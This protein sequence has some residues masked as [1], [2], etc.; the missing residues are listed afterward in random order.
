MGETVDLQQM[1]GK[2]IIQKHIA[3]PTAALI[4]DLVLGE[5]HKS[6]GD[7]HLQRRNLGLVFFGGVEDFRIHVF[8][9]PHTLA[10]AAS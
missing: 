1:V 8:S 9:C 6:Q 5:R 3:Q 2:D 7:E 4:H 10:E